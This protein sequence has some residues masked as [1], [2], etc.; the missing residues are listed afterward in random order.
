M[1]HRWYEQAAY[2]AFHDIITMG[3]IA[4]LALSVSRLEV[5]GSTVL[6]WM[7]ILASA[8][9]VVRYQVLKHRAVQ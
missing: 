7:L 1:E 9:V 6:L 3:G 2:G 5:T 4:L 8:D